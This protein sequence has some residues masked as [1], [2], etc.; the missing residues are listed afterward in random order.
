MSGSPE[1]PPQTAVKE[2]AEAL[3]LRGRPRPAVRF[4]RG[5]IVGAAAFGSAAMVGLAWSAFDPPSFRMA[6]GAAS[7]P[8]LAPT[9]PEPLAGAPGSYGEVLQ[10]GPP[11][12]GDLG[13]PIL[14]QQRIAEAEQAPPAEPFGAAQSHDADEAQ[15]QRA[16]AERKAARE[17]PLLVPRSGAGGG[18]AAGAA[19]AQEP[20][21]MRP[22]TPAAAGREG[23]AAGPERS[24]ALSPGTVIPASLITGLRSDLPGVAVAQVTENVRAS[25]TP[26]RVLVPQGSRL[27]GSYDN[28]VAYGQRRALLVWNRIVFPDGASVELDNLPASDMSGHAGLEDRVDAHTFRLLKGI[29]LSTLLGIGTQISLGSSESDLVRAVREATQQ[30]AARS[31]DRLVARGLDVQPTI[32]IRPGWPV[33]AVLHKEIL[34]PLW[35]G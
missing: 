21:A 14:E 28:V 25:G 29:A 24:V 34:L 6:E 13:R 19:A 5:V 27:I 20:D 23:R 26:G 2:D 8:E 35:E 18:P 22:G 16:A 32:T 15:R 10:L 31:G 33:R 9:T 7:P 4:R 3:V 12:P 11:L 1:R 30:N 17:S